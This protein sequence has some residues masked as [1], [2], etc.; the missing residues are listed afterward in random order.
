MEGKFSQK[1]FDRI[2]L[3]NPLFRRYSRVRPITD[4]PNSSYKQVV[5]MREKPENQTNKIFKILNE[6]MTPTC[7]Y[8]FYRAIFTC[9]TAQRTMTANIR[10]FATVNKYAKSIGLSLSLSL[11]HTHTL[12]SLS[13]SLSLLSFQNFFLQRTRLFVFYFLT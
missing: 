4:R 8:P 7:S 1:I 2:N 3:G 11:T 13:L 12:L 10:N 9:H 5:E 6:W